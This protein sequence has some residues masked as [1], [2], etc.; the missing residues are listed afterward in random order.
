MGNGHKCRKG[1]DKDPMPKVMFDG[2]T[3]TDETRREGLYCG[4]TKPIVDPCAGFPK[5]QGEC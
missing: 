2:V 3:P 1:I 5:C 4:C